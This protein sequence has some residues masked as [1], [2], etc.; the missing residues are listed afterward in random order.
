MEQYFEVLLASR[1]FAGVS[2]AELEAM[3]VCLGGRVARY[4]RDGEILGAGERTRCLGLVLSGTV[5]VLREDF[6][7]TGISSRR[8]GPEKCLEKAMPA[9]RR[10]RFPSGR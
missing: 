7:E 3:L 8:Q 10:K 2:R 6:G 1:L 5:Y 4:A 9:C